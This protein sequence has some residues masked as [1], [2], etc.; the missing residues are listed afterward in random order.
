MP[1]VGS[2]LRLLLSQALPVLKTAVEACGA[3]AV[4]DLGPVPL[5][6]TLDSLAGC[7][8]IRDDTL[9]APRPLFALCSFGLST[10]SELELA[11]QLEFLYSKAEYVALLDFKVAERNI[12]LPACALLSPFRRMSCNRD[13]LFN[14]LNGLEGLLFREAPRFTPSQR[15]TF[16][17][18]GL[19]CI[20]TQCRR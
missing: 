14:A 8:I 17:G 9:P 12:E 3:E 18:G 15:Y 2:P 7:P 10:L 4:L 5:P 20:L 16:G 11:H 13:S 6:D 1:A 19:T